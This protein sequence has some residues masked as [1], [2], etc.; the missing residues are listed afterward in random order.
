MKRTLLIGLTI[1]VIGA[2]ADIARSQILPDELPPVL[3][4]RQPPT[5]ADLNR[6]A[7]EALLIEARM[8]QQREKFAAA[9]R[10]YQRAHRLS[11]DSLAILQ[12]IVQVA[13]SQ[14]RMEEGSRYALLLADR[15]EDASADFLLLMGAYALEQ[16]DLKRAAELY[17]RGAQALQER[18]AI[19]QLLAT[20][21]RLLDLYAKLADAPRAAAE[22]SAILRL[23]QED[24]PEVAAVLD[25]NQGRGGMT[26]RRALGEAFLSNGDFKAAEAQF[27]AAIDES[28]PEQ[29]QLQLARIDLAA[30]R[31]ESAERRLRQVIAAQRDIA[32]GDLPYRLLREIWSK[33]EISP[34]E[35][36]ARLLSELT[37]PY[38]ANPKNVPLGL[39]LA[40]LHLGEEAWE[41]A[42]AMVRSQQPEKAGRRSALQTLAIAYWK[43]QNWPELLATLSEA[44]EQNRNLSFL[45]EQLSQ[46]AADDQAVSGLTAVA[47]AEQ[48]AQDKLSAA[49]ALAIAQLFQ[50]RHQ[51]QE[52]WKW[53]EIANQIDSTAVAPALVDFGVAWLVAKKFDVGEKALRAAI[54]A[55]LPKSA[56]AATYDYLATLLAMDDR[57]DEAL[58][59]AKRGIALNPDSAALASRVPWI[60]YLAGRKSESERSYRRLLA[61]FD[62]QRDDAATRQALRRARLS[63]SALSQDE[64]Q[65]EEWLEQILD[66]FPE[67]VGAMNDLAYLWADAGRNLGRATDMLEEAVAAEPD[68]AAFRD[69]LGWAYYR[70]GRYEQAIGQLRQAVAKLAEPDPVLLD[71][72][73]DALAAAGREQEAVKAWREAVAL[74]GKED[75][76][77]A[78]VEAKI[79][80]SPDDNNSVPR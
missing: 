37:P 69:S 63:L 70:Q 76:Q 40:Q 12:S 49:T 21:L 33:Q 26:I 3:V 19:S 61:Q 67:D 65:R 11:P 51:E 8:L 39:F 4:P 48:N 46:I 18:E 6:T 57:I 22:A 32:A 42:I 77:R 53:L 43:T 58:S 23:I 13:F 54:S 80:A 59:T 64:R 17:Q 36:N 66:E 78:A 68:N 38:K 60:L 35:I 5:E 62:S 52:A 28:E 79:S 55:K 10:R 25:S 29:L 15:Q 41:Q 7:V 9:Q 72:L 2:S 75:E 16:G 1:F 73:G 20:R 45:K 34:Q 74:L 56:R 31:F 50:L 14:K 24:R 44:A 27:R 71:H 47:E 30:E